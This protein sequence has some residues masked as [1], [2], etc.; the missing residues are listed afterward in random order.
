MAILSP[1]VPTLRSSLTA[2]SAL[3]PPFGVWLI[4]Q[5]SKPPPQRFKDEKQTGQ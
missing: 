4:R 3:N 2:I 5:K 1:G